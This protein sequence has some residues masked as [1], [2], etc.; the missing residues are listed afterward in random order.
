[1]KEVETLVYQ[2][3]I[4]DN[5]SGGLVSMLNNE[6][7]RILHAYE[8]DALDS[9]GLTFSIL[10]SVAGSVPAL[11]REVFVSFQIFSS[12]YPDIARRLVRLF[13]RHQHDLSLISGGAMDVGSVAS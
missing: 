13:D 11:T 12:S 1:M 9:P 10:S 6:V 8:R 7:A 4:R 3:M 2:R 5:G